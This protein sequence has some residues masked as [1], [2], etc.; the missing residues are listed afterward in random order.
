MHYD[1]SRYMVG[2]LHACI[3]GAATLKEVSAMSLSY[4]ARSQGYVAF[5]VR[6]IPDLKQRLVD[7]AWKSG[8]SQVAIVTQALEEYL[9]R[10]Q[11]QSEPS[12]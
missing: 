9:A 6:L 2:K 4:P 5:Q 12:V 7:Y 11:S 3:A 10:H 8:Q 1:D